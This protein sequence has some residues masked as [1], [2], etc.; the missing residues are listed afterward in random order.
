MG[1][2]STGELVEEL[3]DIGKLG[4]GFSAVDE[5][6]EVD[7]GTDGVAQPTYVSA[8]LLDEQREEVCRLLRGIL[9]CFAWDYK[10][11]P[12]LSRE[13]DEHGLP[14]KKGFKPHKQP[15]RNYNS[16]LLDRIKDEIQQ[17]LKAGFIRTCRY[18]E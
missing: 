15:A 14:I 10:E 18:A 12:G 4:L 2:K 8:N 13:L 11:L 7:I 3:D 6:I 5:L 1:E 17:L 9:D 16:E